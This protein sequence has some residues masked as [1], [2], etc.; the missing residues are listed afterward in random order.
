M[1]SGELLTAAGKNGCWMRKKAS[2]TFDTPT[3]TASTPLSGSALRA[4]LH[5][6]AHGSTANV[7][8]AGK[9]EVVLGNALKEIGAPR[10][11]VVILTKV[12]NPVGDAAEGRPDALKLERGYVNE[13]GLSRKVRAMMRVKRT[14][15][16]EAA[17]GQ[18][19]FDSVQASLKRL[20]LDYIDVLQCHR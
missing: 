8:S 12:F 11:S 17:D 7:Y 10:E 2:S 3:R 14:K 20:Q 4:S 15:V 1:K 18:H 6:I 9:S 16:E 13:Q 5:V 19:I